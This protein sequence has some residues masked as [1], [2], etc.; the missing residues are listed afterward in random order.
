MG[1]ALKF[2]PA[3]KEAS[4]EIGQ[5][6]LNDSHAY[7]R[8]VENAAQL[9]VIDVIFQIEARWRNCFFLSDTLQ[10]TSL[11]SGDW[12]HLTFQKGDSIIRYD[13]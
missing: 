3:I 11:D 2:L 9:L 5:R 1:S 10:L 12:Q 13:A 6:L 4:P 8:F 7:D